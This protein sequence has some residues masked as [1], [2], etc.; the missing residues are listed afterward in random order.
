VNAACPEGFPNDLDACLTGGYSR[1]VSEPYFAREREGAKRSV[2][3]TP[4]PAP[5]DP[6]R[7]GSL[8]WAS[9][10]GNQAV[11]RL[12][13]QAAGPEEEE[14]VPAEAEAAEAPAAGPEAEGAETEAEIPE[15]ELPA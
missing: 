12:A 11:A 15:D 10:V 9:A 5:A 2:R 13:R 3:R 8:A 7:P 1:L 14:Q 4:E 6:V